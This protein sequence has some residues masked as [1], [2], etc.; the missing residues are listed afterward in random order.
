VQSW[1]RWSAEGTVSSY[2]LECAKNELYTIQNLS[3]SNFQNAQRLTNFHLQNQF[4][5]CS[6]KKDAF[7]VA[8]EKHVIL[9]IQS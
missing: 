8:K 6:P 9:T 1:P 3:R 2:E 5:H 7:G 4:K